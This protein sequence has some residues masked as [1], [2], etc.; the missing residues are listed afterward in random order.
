MKR[1][2][3]TLCMTAL[4]GVVSTTALALTKVGNVYQI[5]SAAD[6]YEFAN[7]VNNGTEPGADAV[8][9]ANIDYT[10]YTTG[11]I[12]LNESN[13][14]Y[15]GTFDGQGHTVTTNI[16]NEAKWTGL[17]GTVDGATI[18]NLI[19]DGSVE[20]PI[21]GIGGLGGLSWG[22]TKIENVVVKSTVKV[23]PAINGNCTCGGIFGDMEGT[24]ASLTNCAFY[25]SINVGTGGTYVG[26]LI[27]YTNK[28]A[29]TNCLVAISSVI[30]KYRPRFCGD[31]NPTIVNSYVLGDESHQNPITAEQIASGEGCY[32]LNGDQSVISW[33]Q[34]LGTDDKPVPF[35]SHSRVYANGE[36]RCDGSAVS[37]GTLTYSNSSTSTIPPHTDVNGWCS[38]CGNLIED[39]LT[40]DAE[41]FYNIATAPDLNWFAAYV[42]A[43]HTAA[44]AKLTDNIDYTASAYT[45]VAAMIGN[46]ASN[47][48]QGTFDG[49]NHT[50]TVAFNYT[51][52][53]TALFR[54]TIGATIKNLKVDGTITTTHKFAG[55]I[56]S[57]ID[58]GESGT[59]LNCESAVTIN[60]S[61]NGDATHGGIV[62]AATGTST[63]IE[64]CLF[65]GS[66]N[67]TSC[68]YCGGILGYGN[69]NATVKNCLV[70]GT[71]NIKTD[72]NTHNIIARGAAVCSGNYYVGT[73]SGLATATGNN[74]T[75]ATEAQ[76]ASGELCYLLNGST[77]GGT[78]WYQNL[79]S[80]VDASP[81]PF[82]THKS[83]YRFAVTSAEYATF[84][85]RV[86]VEAL[87][88]GVIAYAAQK[89][90]TRIHLEPV[91]EI[92]ADNAVVVKAAEG[93]YYYNSTTEARNLGEEND[94]TFSDT[95]EAPDGKYILAKTETYGV[96]FYPAQN[97]VIPAG[98]G[99]IVIDNGNDVKPF[100][101]F[102][103]D[104]ATGIASLIVKAEKE[105]MIYNLVG[106][107]I[108]KA[109][110]GINIING[111]KVL[112]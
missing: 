11:F 59:I 96:G 1:K 39:H 27:G 31:G 76:K 9:T 77:Q 90:P 73:Y 83:V 100:Y 52:H 85:P 7:L 82:A 55:G 88:S 71:M 106:Q 17:F 97:S 62:G 56:V 69:A 84:V 57:H 20:S 63:R 58:T 23:S 38:V 54:R 34:T 18:R 44:N 50:V 28:V 60:G 8:L 75:E 22:A 47:R 36:L 74:G 12:G 93:T 102:N 37:G 41:G 24:A 78:G 5:G 40:P 29:L 109:Q 49:Q 42:N 15:T 16:V 103:E 33:Y 104:D 105:V 65:S 92:P 94:L 2:L 35:S 64:N 110:Q 70:T 51:D 112:K 87:P 66:I 25:G 89:N 108:Q 98:K 72:G 30:S 21:S 13:K 19:V 46:S 80:D 107:R 53:E 79:S 14:K 91:T 10:A 3:L 4:L 43:G 61:V 48:Y 81:V 86:N 99:Y 95:D 6:L 111:K 67:G 68:T 101:G 32:M 26:G 45:G